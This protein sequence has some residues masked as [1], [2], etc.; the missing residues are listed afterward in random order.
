MHAERFDRRVGARRRSRKRHPFR[1]YDHQTACEHLHTRIFYNAV[2]IW[3]VTFRETI[4]EAE[5]IMLREMGNGRCKGW[6]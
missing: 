1:R 2:T 6:Q 5:I 4:S 3:A